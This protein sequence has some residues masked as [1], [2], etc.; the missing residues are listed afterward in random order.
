M[1]WLDWTV[2]LGFFSW[3]IYDGLKRSKDST[4][5]EAGLTLWQLLQRVEPHVLGM[6]RLLGTYQRA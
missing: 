2:L 3:I 6:N 5:L 4:E 1:H